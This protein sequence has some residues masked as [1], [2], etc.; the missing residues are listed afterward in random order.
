MPKKGG[1]RVSCDAFIVISLWLSICFIFELSLL[2]QQKKT[3]THSTG[4]PEGAI[5]PDS[6]TENIPR[7]IVAKVGKVSPIVKGLI[8]DIRRVMG[9]YTAMNLKERK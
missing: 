1:K 6:Q 5:I 9:P 4:A 2:F 8:Q 3:K 7:S